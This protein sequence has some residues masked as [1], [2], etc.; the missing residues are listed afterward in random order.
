MTAFEGLTAGTWTLDPAHSE[1]AFTVRHAG[2]GKTRGQFDEFEGTI[3]VAE[4]IA[5]SKAEATIKATSIN[6]GN[7]DRDNHLRS[8]DFFD[9]ET[10]PE[11]TVADVY[12]ANSITELAATIDQMSSPTGRLND[13]VVKVRRSTQTLQVVASLAVRQFSAL[14]WLTWLGAGANLAHASGMTWVPTLS[15]WW[16]LVGWVLFVAPPGR[17]LLAAG[18]ART[19]LAGVTPGA[20]SRGGRTHLR[21]WLAERI[22]DELGAV[23][24]RARKGGK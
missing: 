4:N 21:V 22:A 16:I 12:E 20:Y 24:A 1:V 2:I 23:H 15:W 13:N 17:M 6:T 10:N 9:A 19:I 5:D 7:E 3:T 8:G 18:F 14:R 11:I